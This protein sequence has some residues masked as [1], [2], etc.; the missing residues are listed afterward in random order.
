MRIKKPAPTILMKYNRLRKE[1]LKHFMMENWEAEKSMHRNAWPKGVVGKTGER[2]LPL[3]DDY[4]AVGKHFR[5]HVILQAR[6]AHQKTQ[7]LI[8]TLF[9]VWEDR[10]HHFAE[11]E[12]EATKLEAQSLLNDLKV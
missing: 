12:N 7:K 3:K 6:P 9:T 2:I 5:N 8:N 10:P 1:F 11:L 4:R